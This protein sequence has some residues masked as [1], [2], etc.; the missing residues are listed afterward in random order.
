MAGMLTIK[1]SSTFCMAG[2]PVRSISIYA[3]YYSTISQ[4]VSLTHRANMQIRLDSFS[5]AGDH[6][7]VM[8][9]AFHRHR[10]R[11]VGL[12]VLIL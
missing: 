5:P 2:V 11:T 12:V 9:M 1:A 6:T 3:H 4:S 10:R 7:A 8:K